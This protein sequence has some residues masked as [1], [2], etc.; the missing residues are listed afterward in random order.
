MFPSVGGTLNSLSYWLSNF[1]SLSLSFFFSQT[2]LVFFSW[3]FL[4]FPYLCYLSYFVTAHVSFLI[5]QYFFWY[6]RF[7]LSISLAFFTS[8]FLLSLSLY[9]YIHCFLPPSLLIVFLYI[10]SG[11]V[12]VCVSVQLLDCLYVSLSPSN[13]KPYKNRLFPSPVETSYCGQTKRP[14]KKSYR[15]KCFGKIK[16][17]YGLTNFSSTFFSLH[18]LCKQNCLG[19]GK[20]WNI[21]KST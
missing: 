16:S 9:I 15:L 21:S 12:Y 5:Y 14:W 13:T 1:L 4:F 19:G 17:K 2:L 20:T 10:L 6:T 8:L 11:L 3:I 7:T 18:I